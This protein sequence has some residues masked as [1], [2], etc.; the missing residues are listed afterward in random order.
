M[1]YPE[2]VKA[3]LWN[4]ISEMAAY[5][6]LFAKNPE[7]DFSRKRMLDF[8]NLLR[9]SISIENGSTKYEL[10]KYFD[11]DSDTITSS[12]FSQQRAK[13]LPVT[14]QY[15]LSRFN[16]H[17]PLEKYREKYQLVLS[18]GSEFNIARDP[19]DLSTYHPPSGKS[20]KGFN[21]LH[22][23]SLFDVLN[24]RYLDCVIQPGR[25]KNEFRAICDLI[26]RY[27]FEETPIL[28]MDRG[29]AAYN[30][31]AHAIEKGAFFIIRAKDV[32]VRRMLTV[33]DLPDQV[34]TAVN[35]I[36]TRTGARSKRKHPEL[37]DQYRYISPDVSFDFIEPKTSGEYP[38]S[39]RI[40]RFEVAD[41]IYENIITNLPPDEFPPG[42]I[43]DLYH[44]RWGIETSFRDLKH[45]IGA[46]SLHS[47]KAEY[48]E[49]EIRARLIMYNF[50]AVIAGYVVIT[51]KDTKHT[52]QVNFS[53]AIKICRT[54]LRLACGK[55]PPD[56]I[57]LI[58]KYTLPIRPGRSFVRR[59][60]FQAP[61]SFCYRFS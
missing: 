60:R 47:K 54:L 34:D 5:P 55:K 59:H 24:K 19:E 31:Y 20:T 14:F 27:P 12:A 52:Y 30:V 7:S 17:F 21:T 23:I 56:V 57:G 13:L 44:M 22:T 39:L 45:T 6:W 40:V 8:E 53:M 43:K 11:Y 36:L 38:L 49:L 18:D 37:S 51:A 9:F 58:G 46:T 15:L 48:I 50:C 10:L 16:S 41:G 61:V 26:D 42:E 25:E 33:E 3:I 1:T 4:E 35:L 28:I 29:F 2:E 32:N